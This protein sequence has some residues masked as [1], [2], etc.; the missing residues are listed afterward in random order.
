[1]TPKEILKKMDSDPPSLAKTCGTRHGGVLGLFLP[2]LGR[3][4]PELA[5]S[6]DVRG[7]HGRGRRRV[8][9]GSAESGTGV[10]GE[11]IPH[12]GNITMC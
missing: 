12:I 5:S 1:M 10:V 7:L 9:E 3:F 11:N 2:C 4:P 8:A 6:Q